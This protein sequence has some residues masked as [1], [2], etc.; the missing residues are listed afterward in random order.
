MS[1][2]VCAHIKV[3]LLNQHMSAKSCDEKCTDCCHKA[4][5]ARQVH[6]ES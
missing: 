4:F 6:D 1:D 5:D 3:K 2:L